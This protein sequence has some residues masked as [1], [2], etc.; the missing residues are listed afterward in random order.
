MQLGSIPPFGIYSFQ[1]TQIVLN[2]WRVYAVGSPCIIDRLP[3]VGTISELF[4]VLGERIAFNS[5]NNSN[6]SV[7]IFCPWTKLVS[8][9][10][11]RLNK[12]CVWKNNKYFWIAANVL[13][14]INSKAFINGDLTNACC[15][16]SES[17]TTYT[18]IAVHPVQA[19]NLC[20]CAVI[21]I[22]HSMLFAEHTLVAL[23]CVAVP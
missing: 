11:Q 1:N 3:G 9:I 21:A 23:G 12:H 17:H 10:F 14:F 6:D 20:D 18:C 22:G 16:K 19:A 5:P 13:M 8:N 15:M 2:I 4:L 7:N